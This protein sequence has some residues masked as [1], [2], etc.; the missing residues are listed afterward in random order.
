MRIIRKAI[1]K[2]TRRLRVNLALLMLHM[3][4]PR[5]ALRV[6]GLAPMAGGARLLSQKALVRWGTGADS[7]ATQ[8][9]ASTRNWEIAMS[10]DYAE[11]TAHGDTFKLKQPT[12]QD[13]QVTVTGLFDDSGASGGSKQIITDALAKTS[14]RFYLYPDSTITSIY[15]SGRGYLAIDAHN[16]P[17]ND[18]SGFNFSLVAA[19]APAF[20]G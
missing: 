1:R 13:F 15:W 9:I 10:P 11:S 17:Y 14:G 19:S 8:A 16:A 20:N 2:Y 6:A 3:V 18:Y 5:I 4:T 7:T 12:F